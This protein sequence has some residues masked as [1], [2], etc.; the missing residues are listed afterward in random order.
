MERVFLEKI[1][2]DYSDL[3]NNGVGEF[4]IGNGWYPILE[5]L[6]DIIS[7]DESDTYIMQVKE[8]FGSLRF[9]AQTTDFNQGAI[10]LAEAFSSHVCEESGYPGHIVSCQGWLKTLAPHVFNGRD[11]KIAE[12]VQNFYCLANN[13]FFYKEAVTPL[14]IDL[15]KID[16][17]SILDKKSLKKIPYGFSDLLA[18]LSQFLKREGWVGENIQPYVVDSVVFQENEGL[19]FQCQEESDECLGAIKF[20]EMISRKIDPTTG[21][22]KL[23]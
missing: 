12:S 7:E 8:K 19:I 22:V 2:E 14:V 11:I 13:R 3:Y 4:S 1:K 20:A 16:V 18:V 5:S 21:V 15:E 17:S 6:L 10:D 9:Y 23:V